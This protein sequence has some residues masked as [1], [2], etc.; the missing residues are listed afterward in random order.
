MYRITDEKGHVADLSLYTYSTKC[1]ICTIESRVC[2][3]CKPCKFNMCGKCAIAQRDIKH[4]LAQWRPLVDK[5]N[6]RL[7]MISVHQL[8]REN[9]AYNTLHYSCDVCK[10]EKGSPAHCSQC[11]YDLCFDCQRK[12]ACYDKNG[13]PMTTMGLLKMCTKG[14]FTCGACGKTT[15]LIGNLMSTT[16]VAHCEKCN[17][18]VCASCLNMY[19]HLSL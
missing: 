2:Y 4:K 10:K 12:G 1:N 13:H 15:K 19:S 17:I 3:S 16:K 8:A 9:P 18:V 11:S 5:N 14:G 7:Q 6:H